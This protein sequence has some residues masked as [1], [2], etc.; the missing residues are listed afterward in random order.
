M[1]RKILPYVPLALFALA[2]LA[3]V[4]PGPRTI[5]D[6][7]ITFRYARNL[8]DGL[9]FVYNPGQAVLGTTTPLFTLLLALV[10]L[11]FGGAAANFPA[12]A[13]GIS[14]VADGLTAVLL[15]T[16]GRRLGSRPAGLAAALAWAVAPFSVTFAIGGLE[17]SVYVLLLV[18]IM[19]AYLHG[20]VLLAAGLSA[21][22]VLTRPDAVLLVAP[23]L[24]WHALRSTPNVWHAAFWRNN[25]RAIA[26]FL[27]PLLGWAVWAW[28]TFGSPI[29]QSVAAKSNA[30]RL[31]PLAALSN[32]V[33]FYATPFMEHLT[34]GVYWLYVGLW[35]YPFLFIA[36][37][38]AAAKQRPDSLPFSVFPWLY[39]AA[40]A[41]GNPLVFRWYLTPPLP[42]YILFICLGVH[43]LVTKLPAQLRGT[44]LAAALATVLVLLPSLSLLRGWTLQPA[45]P[46]Q[47]P[48]P[49]MAWI[50]LE[51]LYAQAADSLQPA[52]AAS[53]APVTL[54]AGDV[55]VLGY[56]LPE[57]RILD[58]V[59]L[60]SKE[61]LPYYP[62]DAAYYGD[63]LYA[64]SPELI[65]HELPDYVVMLEIYGRHGLLQDSRFIASY[66]L[67]Q[68]LPTEIYGTDGLLIYQRLP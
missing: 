9:G 59:G 30:Y 65:M 32:F 33:N 7:F 5:D 53:T 39:F 28:L 36:G 22:A 10:A 27:A 66:Q 40:F 37:A 19:W 52:L 44:R 50:E 34:F 55:G 54:A 26:V 62:L 60:N 31:E 15:Y 1:L 4:L 48:A 14:A 45:Q 3:R 63:F 68:T 51:L 67:L 6:A 64:I 57:T 47:R 18:G 29:A 12:L 2:V 61:T 8:L 24:A 46:P 17:T 35:L 38:W 43:T 42:F 25:A 49:H 58:L 13:L 41:I 21:A 20:R 11:P 16:L 23:L 56:L